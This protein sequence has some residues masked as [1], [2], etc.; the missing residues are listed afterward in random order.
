MQISNSYLMKK[1][2]QDIT[3]TQ[4]KLQDLAST[5]N[6]LPNLM[7]MKNNDVKSYLEMKGKIID[8]QRY[9]DFLTT[10]KREYDEFHQGLQSAK[11]LA[12]QIISLCS[13][14]GN[15]GQDV[16]NTCPEQI[17]DKENKARKIVE[18]INQI[19]SVGHQALDHKGN[20]LEYISLTKYRT[21]LDN[22]SRES[23]ERF[24]NTLEEMDVE[25]NIKKNQETIDKTIKLNQEE[26]HNLGQEIK[27]K[28]WE[29]H[30]DVLKEL[31]NQMMKYQMIQEANRWEDMMFLRLLNNIQ[32]H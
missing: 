14:E 21:Y 23:A 20:E 25:K 30:E 7:D 12:S 6:Y 19:R 16:Y 3:L 32:M 11:K 24:L 5:Q 27:D 29:K 31:N 2:I 8:K 17:F 4:R 22:N 15:Q 10:C 18:H 13:L 26:L 1:A 9:K 28:Y